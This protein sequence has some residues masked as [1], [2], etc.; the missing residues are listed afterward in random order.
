MKITILLLSLFS[1]SSFADS[2][3]PLSAMGSNGMDI[4]DLSEPF[5][6]TN[7]SVNDV[8]TKRTA[9]EDEDCLDKNVLYDFNSEE[10]GAKVAEFD[11]K[12][13]SWRFSVRTSLG[14]PKDKLQKHFVENTS[15]RNQNRND[16]NSIINQD[17]GNYENRRAA[18]AA[19]CEGKSEADRIEMASLLAGR[20]GG[21]YDYG[22]ANG[23][24]SEFIPPEDQ[25]D[26]LRTGGS[27]GVC[28]DA[29]LTVSHFL[30][31]CGFP[32]SIIDIEGY[33]TAGGGHQVVTVT[34]SNGD[35]YTI[36][37][38]ELFRM[39]QSAT[40]ASSPQASLLNAGLYHTVYDA[41]TGAVKSRQ[42]SELALALKSLTGG[43]VDPNL[44]PNVNAFEASNG[45]LAFALFN[46]ETLMGDSAVGAA[47]TY[48]KEDQRLWGTLSTSFGVGV[49]QNTKSTP[50]S[51]TENLKLDQQILYMQMDQ[52]YRINTPVYKNEEGVSLGFRSFA[53][54]NFE[55]FVANNKVND[56]TKQTLDIM[57]EPRVG[58]DLYLETDDFAAYT[59]GSALF[60]VNPFR[61]NSADKRGGLSLQQ[62]EVHGGVEFTRGRITTAAESRMII[63]KGLTT[64]ST[65]GAVKIDGEKLDSQISAAYSIYDRGYG[66]REDY[67]TS[68]IGTS[69][70]IDKKGRSVDLNAGVSV[71]VMDDF[72]NTRF[73]FGLGIKF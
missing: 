40:V 11:Q 30:S 10:E 70:V 42:R 13:S 73:N 53:G 4:L 31:S 38:S 37:W 8:Y 35:R 5:L 1:F 64:T 3:H 15:N 60:S 9:T 45:T 21:I 7:G 2:S 44:I 16:L 49:A 57:V 41:E 62:Y 61:T 55:G 22:R 51:P 24:S 50:T 69:Y 29:A 34:D 27:T 63:A 52:E 19:M 20:L 46:V 18:I 71:P 6:V 56:E 39:D 12:E 32:A 33:R 67:V 48:K 47:G 68:N 59:G 17:F 14:G 36:N 28:R 23:G 54:Y 65:G 25:W 66:I 72:N 26:T 58:S 43:D